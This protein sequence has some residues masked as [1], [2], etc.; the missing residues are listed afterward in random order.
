MEGTP[1]PPQPQ[2]KQGTPWTLIAIAVLAVYALLIV[3]LNREE[4][5][6]SFV[7]FSTR[8]SKLVLIV[9]CLGI[10]FVLGYLFDGWRKRG[11][12]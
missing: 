1:P 5:G 8:I 6:I 9:L 10:G 4:V 2:A 7:F 3:I 11:R 12:E